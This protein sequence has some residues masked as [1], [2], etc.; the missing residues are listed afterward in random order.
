MKDVKHLAHYAN[1]PNIARFLTDG[2]PHPY[3]EEDARN[4][5]RLALEEEIPCLFAIIVD[6]HPVGSIGIMLQKDIYCKNAEIG[7][8]LAEEYWGRGIMPEAIRLI[9]E[10][11]FKTFDITRVYARPF[12]L[13]PRSQRVLEKAGFRLEARLEK[14][15]FKNGE[16]TDELIYAK[17][18]D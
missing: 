9:T 13:N 4:F 15:Y 5:I 6:D 8:F 10:Y 14:T 17:R 2:F 11:A 1:N 18:K 3:S 16:F 7:Y 12:G